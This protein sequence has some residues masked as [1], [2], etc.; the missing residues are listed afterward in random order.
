MVWIK[1]DLW[2][3]SCYKLS[4]LLHEH[5]FTAGGKHSCEGRFVS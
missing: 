1:F 5:K 2:G 3:K 4:I